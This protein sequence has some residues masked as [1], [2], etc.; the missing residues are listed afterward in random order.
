[1][2]S[3]GSLGLFVCHK[4]RTVLRKTYSYCPGCGEPIKSTLETKSMKAKES[5]GVNPD[6]VGI[7]MDV[8]G[9]I[10]VDLNDNDRLQNIFGIPVSKSLVVVSDNNDLRIEDAG[11]KELS[12]EDAESFLKVLDEVIKANAI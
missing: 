1:M 4:C 5:K 2:E 8:L 6:R 9:D 3:A 11:L 10:I 12:E 7:R